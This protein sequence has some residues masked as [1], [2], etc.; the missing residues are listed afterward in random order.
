ME[1]FFIIHDHKVFVSKF[2]L[3]HNIDSYHIIR[4]LSVIIIVKKV[5]CH[6]H[7]QM[8]VRTKVCMN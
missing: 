2:S 6:H 5:I 1:F 8:I 4:K 3:F 7:C